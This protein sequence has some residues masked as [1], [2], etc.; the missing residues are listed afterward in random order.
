[1]KNIFAA[2]T[3]EQLEHYEGFVRCIQGRLDEY[4][5]FLC[6]EYEVAQLPP[7]IVW[8]S[9]EIATNTLSNIP[10]PAYTN[11]KRIVM[12]PEMSSWKKIYLRQLENYPEQDT[13]HIRACYESIAENQ[14][15]QILGHELAHHSELFLDSEDEGIWFE[16][17]MVEYLSRSYFLS[18]GEFAAQKKANE[19]LMALFKAK[20]GYHSLEQFGAASYAGDYAGIFY[21][22]WRSFL[23]VEK[24]V[25]GHDGNV[26]AVFDAYHKWAEQPQQPLTEWF[27]VEI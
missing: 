3:A 8:T 27:G 11:E 1:M 26:R 10:I 4:I 25:A 7:A 24:I 13:A 19:E 18:P 20:H 23:A 15:M 16:E 14:I 2:E 21:E 5:N 22:Y 12:C 6:R 17:G 9:A